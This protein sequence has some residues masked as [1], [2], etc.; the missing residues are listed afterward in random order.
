MVGSS[1]LPRAAAEL[2]ASATTSIRP[3]A[4]CTSAHAARQLQGLVLLCSALNVAAML[5]KGMRGLDL[6]A[7]G[8][9][10]A[11]P[12][13]N[14]CATRT[15]AGRPRCVQSLLPFAE[16]LQT[17]RGFQYLGMKDT[18]VQRTLLLME[19]LRRSGSGSGPCVGSASGTRKSGQSPVAEPVP[20]RIRLR[21]PGVP[22]LRN[23]PG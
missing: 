17:V 8:T 4:A 6:M 11:C 18:I 19:E 1:L 16:C 2:A 12:A 7:P 10:D 5:P 23:W 15:A 21:N 22:G 9:N 13:R 20:R 14:F 3:V